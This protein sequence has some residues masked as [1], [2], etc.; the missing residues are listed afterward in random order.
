MG[1]ILI[2]DDNK[3]NREI[4][5]AFLKGDH[6]I[7]TVESGEDCLNKLVMFNPDLILMDWMMPGL[8]GLETLQIIRD[9]PEF[10]T[11]RIIMLTAKAQPGDITTAWRAG[12][13]DY[14]TKPFEMKELIAA[15]DRQ[16]AAKK[17]LDDQDD[18]MHMME[19]GLRQAQKMEAIG[20]L[21]GG[22]AHDFNNM[23]FPIQ[24]FAEMLEN[25]SDPDVIE[26]A[27]EIKNCARRSSALVRQILSFSRQS[28]QKEQPVAVDLILKEVLKL[29]KASFPATISIQLEI[30]SECALTLA[31]PTNIHQVIMNLCTNA[32]HVM[33]KDGG[34]LKVRL[35]QFQGKP[36]SIGLKSN[37]EYIELSVSDTGGGIPPEIKEKIFD[38]FFTTKPAGKGTG[39]GLSVVHGIVNEIGGT[40]IVK[41]KEG[42]GSTFLVYFPV[43]DDECVFQE[44]TKS[45][46]IQGK[47][48]ILVVDDELMIADMFRKSLKGMGYQVLAY[49]IASEA[50]A[51][52]IENEGIDLLITDMTM[53]EMT[54]LELAERARKLRPD[55]P[56]ILMTGFS[57]KIDPDE[58]EKMGFGFLYKPVGR[59]DLSLAIRQRLDTADK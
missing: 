30:E 50:I 36:E 5:S 19:D 3:Q 25:H 58:A 6:N 7:L 59:Q 29:I 12:A 38:P 31:D 9:M 16:L 35:G 20:T 13:N 45:D 56:I 1:N 37:C 11:V 44:E 43:Q 24:A 17:R 47:E 32:K 26:C 18:E 57:E 34:I 53:P 52:L 33:E 41:S 39:M 49:T 23:L 55:L 48:V 15:V 54:G 21:A 8:D 22:I 10:R 46:V 14:V 51:E 27:E 4:A 42:K 40:I 28:K 2:V